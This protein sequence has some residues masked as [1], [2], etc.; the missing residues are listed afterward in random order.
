MDQTSKNRLPIDVY[1]LSLVRFVVSAGSFVGPFLTMMLTI[2]L[3]YNEAQAGAF[4]SGVSLI[5]AF[6]LVLGG[7]LGDRMDRPFVLKSLQII[8]G[9][10]MLCCAILGF[11]VV[12]PFIIAI[13]MGCLQGSWP[14]MNAIAADVS[15]PNKRKDTFSLMYWANNVGFSVGPLI[16]GFLFI[17]APRLLFVGNSIGLF[18]AALVVS[19]FVKGKVYIGSESIAS[20]PEESFF[21]KKE[22]TKTKQNTIQILL[23]N[24]LLLMYAIASI[25]TAFI[26][27]QQTFALPVFLKDILG[28]EAGPK[29]FGMVMSVNGITVVAL[30]IPIMLIFKRLSYLNCIAISSVFYMFGFG[31]YFFSNSLVTVMI[32]TIIWTIGEILGATS[33]N[34]FIA[35]YAPPL[36]RSRI[37][38]ALSLAHISGNT[39]APIVAGTLVRNMGSKAV[40]PMTAALSALVS[41]AYLIIRSVERKS[42]FTATKPR[43]E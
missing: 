35:E 21:A 22:T 9:S 28:N 40:W 26:Y 1:A 30:T 8:T 27:N 16:A 12:T 4:M 42:K 33:G 20:T 34:A 31:S 32:S 18:I 19:I 23:R 43:D 17:K 39:M 14:V 36:Y 41:L 15:P 29:A 13:A 5:S 11:T 24:P 7:K 25:I 38:S 10:L 6:G 3:G 2:K 37:N